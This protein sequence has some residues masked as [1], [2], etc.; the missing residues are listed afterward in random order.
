MESANKGK[1]SADPVDQTSQTR[2]SDIYDYMQF[3]GSPAP[4]T[5]EM[6]EKRRQLSHSEIYNL[7]IGDAVLTEEES[8]SEP[9]S[10]QSPRERSQSPDYMAFLNCD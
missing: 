1:E 5:P 6:L 7:I 10:T 9:A 8:C 3:N 4:A 2:D